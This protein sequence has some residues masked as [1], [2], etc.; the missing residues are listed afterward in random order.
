MHKGNLAALKETQQEIK[1]E[2]SKAAKSLH[3]TPKGYVQPI[4]PSQQAVVIEKE[5]KVEIEPEKP[6]DESP[7]APETDDDKAKMQNGSQTTPPKPL[8]RSSRANSISEDEPKPVARPRTSPSPGSIVTS[9]N[10]NMAGGY[11]VRMRNLR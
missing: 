4:K 8:P 10:P 7:K 11:K 6:N 5:K 1:V 3:A 2:Q 9:V